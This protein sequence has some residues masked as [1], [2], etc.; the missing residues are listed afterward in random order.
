[1]KTTE[2]SFRDLQRD[3]SPENCR[4]SKYMKETF[5]WRKGIKQSN[6]G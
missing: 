1:M 2:L 6:N 3:K 4:G 5:T